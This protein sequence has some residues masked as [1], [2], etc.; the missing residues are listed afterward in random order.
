MVSRRS[1]LELLWLSAGTYEK[2]AV[3]F[4]EAAVSSSPPSRIQINNRHESGF[5]GW[6]D[7]KVETAREAVPLLSRKKVYPQHLTIAP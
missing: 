6:V 5:G 4:G 1:P 7:E 3:A 2:G